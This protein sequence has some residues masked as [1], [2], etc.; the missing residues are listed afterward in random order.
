MVAKE[1]IAYNQKVI[2]ERSD[3]MNLDIEK[4]QEDERAK[5][6]EDEKWLFLEKENPTIFCDSEM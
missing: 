4:Q 2:G 5:I 6:A 1:Q 3:K